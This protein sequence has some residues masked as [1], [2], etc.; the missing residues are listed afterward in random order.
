MDPG[1]SGLLAI[2]LI[3]LVVACV[4]TFTVWAAQPEAESVPPPPLAA[5]VLAAPAPTPEA[6]VVSVVGLVPRPGLIAL[7]TGD[8]VADAL[9][10]AGGALPGADISALN[11]ARKVSD[12]EQLYVGVPPPPELATGSPVGSA[13]GT[14]GNGNDSKID[15][16]TATEE[17]LDEL[18]GVGEVT[19]KRIVQ[20]R[21]ENGRFA[22][23]EQLREVDGIGD[24]RFSRLRDLV[25][26]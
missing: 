1:R 19:A 8:R 24:T 6:L 17:Q 23:V 10:G 2:T 12:G 3:G 13:R 22:S 11:L 25:R 18:P 26:V 4:I 5:P 9:E 16:N 15:L 14:S 20:W 7:H 21:T